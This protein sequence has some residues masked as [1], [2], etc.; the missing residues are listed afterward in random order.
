MLAAPFKG[1]LQRSLIMTVAQE[2]P[3]VVEER[4]RILRLRPVACVGKHEELSIREMLRQE[5]RVDR[6]DNYVSATMDDQ[7]VLAD[8]TQHRISVLGRNG[9]PF[10]DRF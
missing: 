9:A 6:N 2:A 8:L 3:S 5:K 4:L 10:T 1:L 7:G